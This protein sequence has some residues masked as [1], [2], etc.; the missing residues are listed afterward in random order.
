V[1]AADG[2]ARVQAPDGAT[3]ALS[4]VVVRF[5]G[6]AGVERTLEALVP[7]LEGVAGEAI[8]AHR[9]GEPPTEAMR[10]RF[11]QVRWVAGAADASPARLRTL[12]VLASGGRVV[13]CTEDHCLP[14]PGWAV[15]VVAA[16]ADGVA[17][18]V[19]GA[20]DKSP[21]A[22]G[23]AWAA[24]LLDYARYMSPLPGGA[25]DYVSDCNVSYPRSALDAVADRWREEFHETTVHW[26]LRARGVALQLDPSI[27][28]QQ[29]REVALAAYLDE[30]REHGH[31][32]ARTRVA[33]GVSPVVR[34]RLV[35]TALVLAP[36]LVRRVRQVLAARG[37]AAQVPAEAWSPLR[38]AARAWADGE[39]RGYLG[40]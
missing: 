20:I 38:R 19:G 26:A 4:V 25:A 31:I 32:F 27:V 3:L 23:T 34:L 35:L 15:R 6:G 12:G 29:H 14:A 8:V 2:G 30:R 36:V 22:D 7:Q 39:L 5:V 24:Y 40:R 37:G 17:R 28:V 33:A 13:A 21:T 9:A 1:S 10:Q 18:V 11:P 16:H